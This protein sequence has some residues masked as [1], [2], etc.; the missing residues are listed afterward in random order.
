MTPLQRMIVDFESQYWT[1]RGD[2][3]HAIRDTFE[4]GVARYYQLLVAALNEE[5][6]LQHNP[7]LVNRLR[8]IMHKE[9]S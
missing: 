9:A 8:R 1:H 3:E 5:T 7:V 2:K 6:V 4:F